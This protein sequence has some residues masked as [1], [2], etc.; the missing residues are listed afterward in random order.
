MKKMLTCL[1]V[2]GSMTSFAKNVE[3]IKS[4]IYK[5][6]DVVINNANDIDEHKQS[7]KE[8][9]QTIRQA[10][11]DI[12]AIVQRIPAPIPTPRQGRGGNGGGR[13]ANRPSP[14]PVPG[15]GNGHSRPTTGVINM[16]LVN[17]ALSSCSNLSSIQSKTCYKNFLSHEVGILASVAEGCFLS[18][19]SSS[20]TCY[21]NAMKS[22]LNGSTLEE[23][24]AVDSC[25]KISFDSNGE[26]A[27]YSGMTSTI[28]GVTA[29][30]NEACSK[31]SYSISANTCFKGGLESIINGNKG[32]AKVALE[33]CSKISHDFNGKKRC[34]SE[35]IDSA[36]RAETRVIYDACYDL[37][38]F[39]S[40]SAC[41]EK[42]LNEIGAETNVAKLLRGAC[43]AISHD[44]NSKMKC[45]KNGSESADM[46]GFYIGPY[47]RG[48]ASM[49]NSSQASQCF[50]RA[51]M[52]ITF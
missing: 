50:D 14:A 7:A 18:N 13:G 19:S 22:I 5:L 25:S 45:F 41:F 24:V 21:D 52:A 11:K 27:C 2:V 51:L 31:I 35:I 40:A 39:S 49:N 9:N 28:N 26:K 8:I 6:E 30:L 23:E 15:Y 47:V 10:I 36:K 4:N 46:N 20:K 43:N 38:N 17:S 44:P 1:L 33:A 29:D 12:K 48:C 3:T 34:F 42:G 16:I 32:L 37:S